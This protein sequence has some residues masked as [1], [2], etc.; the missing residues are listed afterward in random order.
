MNDSHQ[1]AFALYTS[2]MIGLPGLGVAS[3][4][5]SSDLSFALV[6]FSIFLAT[7]GELLLLLLTLFWFLVQSQIFLKLNVT[8]VA[9]SECCLIILCRFIS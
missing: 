9:L 4:V 6:V 1:I 5:P 3:V 7:T 8:A 2:L